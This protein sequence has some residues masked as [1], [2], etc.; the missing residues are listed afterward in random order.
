[1]RVIEN[2]LELTKKFLEDNKKNIQDIKIYENDMNIYFNNDSEI[3]FSSDVAEIVLKINDDC[4]T[5]RPLNA[6]ELD[7]LLNENKYLHSE[8]ERLTKRD[9]EKDA[10]IQK[11]TEQINVA[12]YILSR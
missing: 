12:K 2:D 3:Q 1:M 10:I 6:S 5:V 11:L 4:P 8:V 7:D 9:I